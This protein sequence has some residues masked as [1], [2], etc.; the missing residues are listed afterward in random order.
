MTPERGSFPTIV[1]GTRM[2]LWVGLA[3]LGASAFVLVG[4]GELS[5]AQT[6]H[7]LQRVVTPHS[8]VRCV[9][10]SAGWDYSCR[11]TPPRRSG[12]KPFSTLVKVDGHKIIDLSG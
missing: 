7:K 1:S 8:H 6:A 5:A 9:G 3:P 4:C 10:G 2:R 12:V 11:V